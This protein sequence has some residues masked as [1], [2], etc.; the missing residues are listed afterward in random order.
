MRPWHYSCQGLSS[1]ALA[2]EDKK[3]DES[4][5]IEQL[6]SS[7]KLTARSFY[8]LQEKQIEEIKKVYLKKCRLMKTLI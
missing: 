8:W 7:D 6:Y 1:E 3:N 4:N 2:K 5:W